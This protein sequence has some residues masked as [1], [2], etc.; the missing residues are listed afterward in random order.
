MPAITFTLPW[1]PSANHYWRRNGGIYFISSKGIA[2]RNLT[3]SECFLFKGC[4]EN[5]ERLSVK[6]LA[7]PPDRRRRDLDNILK[8]LLDSLQKAGVYADDSQIDSLQLTRMSERSGKVFV[9][10]EEIGD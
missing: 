3:S 4:F 5:K 9:T 6:I 10:I 7:Y 8:C 2:Y 1:P